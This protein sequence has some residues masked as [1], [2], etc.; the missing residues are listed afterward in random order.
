MTPRG[1]TGLAI[2]TLNASKKEFREIFELLAQPSAYPFHLYCQQ[3]KDRTGLT[4]IL[5]LLLLRTP[6][7]AINEDY[8]LSAT[9]L[10]PE[11][12]ER[13]QELRDMGLP[14]SYAGCDPGLVD[15]VVEWLSTEYGDVVGYLSSIGVAKSAQDSIRHN[16]LV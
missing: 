1:L 7:S 4:A 8:L 5:L 13:L 6:Q 10:E 11:K 3:G 14:D 9:E 15:A 12:T 2:D 16:L